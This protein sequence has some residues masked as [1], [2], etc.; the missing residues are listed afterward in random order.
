MTPEPASLLV[1]S[2]TQVAQ[3]IP[4]SIIPPPPFLITADGLDELNYNAQA[5]GHQTSGV[6]APPEK[7]ATA[8]ATSAKQDIGGIG[9]ARTASDSGLI[10]I[11]DG[12]KAKTCAAKILTRKSDDAEKV[13]V[14]VGNRSA[15]TEGE[16]VDEENFDLNDETG[17]VPWGIE[18]WN[19]NS[20][21]VTFDIK[22]ERTTALFQEWQQATY[23]KIL[24][25]YKQKLAK[26]ENKV[27]QAEVESD[28]AIEQRNAASNHQNINDELIGAIDM[29]EQGIPDIDFGKADEQGTIARLFEQ[30][31]EWEE[32]G[33]RS[34]WLNALK[35]NEFLK[36]GM[37]RVVL[38]TRVGFET[39][40]NHS[41]ENGELWRGGLLPRIAS[42]EYLPIA[43]ELASRLR[44]PANEEEQGDSWDV[45]VPSSLIQL[46]LSGD[47]PKW[48][49]KLCLADTRCWD[50]Y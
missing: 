1:V 22:C 10:R 49:K 15:L 23:K 25:A 44:R 2:M 48:E 46:R 4:T 32:M 37:C 11:P 9:S 7:F 29:G 27:H 18:A 19:L 34:E 14:N 31:F 43:D 45:H 35:F 30:A 5:V 20:Y 8:A 21:S 28:A 47:L 38:P 36:A 26:Y 12:Y 42:S 33:R 24:A 39:A 6:T 17:S 16:G 3:E 41:L 40:V 13:A 50:I